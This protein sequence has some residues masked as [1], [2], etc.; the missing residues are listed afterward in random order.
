M[1][2]PPKAQK[3]RQDRAIVDPKTGFPTPEFLR[4]INSALDLLAY[5]ANIEAQAQAAQGT[6]D[7][8]QTA[9][10]N[11]QSSAD[12]A[13]TTADAA[14]PQ[15]RTLTAGAGLTGGGS[16]AANRT[17]DVGAGIG[18]TVNANDVAIDPLI[19]A[20]LTD[21]QTLSGKTLTH[22]IVTSYTVAGVPPSSPDWQII[23]VSNESG[24]G[25]LAFSFGG[26]WLRVT[27][28]AVIS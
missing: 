22:P 1:A 5:L 7:G 14:A 25:V 21:T 20:T 2:N 15:T 16:L 4:N 23:G 26:Q 17:F 19:V 18:I 27:D 10:D 13:Q 3:F 28:R 8:A 9:A 6:A 24:G 11:A 12:S